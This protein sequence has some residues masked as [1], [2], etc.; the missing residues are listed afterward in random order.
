MS[1]D[2]ERSHDDRAF[3]R[4]A[5]QSVMRDAER[6]QDAARLRAMRRGAS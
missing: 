4:G 2:A 5:E 6:S 3:D 1:S